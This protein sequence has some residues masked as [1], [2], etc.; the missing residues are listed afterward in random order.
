[1]ALKNR[2]VE[3]KPRERGGTL[4]SN[5]L[6]FQKDWALCKLLELQLTDQNYV[7]ILDFHDDILIIDSATEP[8][9]AQYYQLKTLSGGGSWTTK[10]LVS[11]KESEE[12]SHLGKLVFHRVSCPDEHV[13]LNFVS[14][15]GYKIKLE[16]RKNA[17]EALN[18]STICMSTLVESERTIINEKIHEEFSQDVPEFFDITY[19]RVT[20]LGIRGHDVY[21]KGKISE[22][23]DSY[24]RPDNRV[25]PSVAYK[26]LIAEI[27][28]RN[29]YEWELQSL[30]DIVCFKGIS[31]EC[32]SDLLEKLINN[33]RVYQNWTGI[34][35]DLLR[36]GAGVK[37]T[38]RIQG[39]WATY[40]LERMNM[41]NLVLQEIRSHVKNALELFKDNDF[42]N[43][44]DLMNRVLT[45]YKRKNVTDYRLFGYDEDY[46]RAIILMESCS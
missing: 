39:Y 5:R 8:Q 40:E 20:D 43:H 42:P 10:S 7:V 18:V 12:F 34:E 36:S 25:N 37:L 31:R 16:G 44:F 22:F 6:Q 2:L 28:K 1:M 13:E 24:A 46:I 19:L 29:D 23:L 30:E 41:T 17:K 15:A 35:Q 21:T 26:M 3:N 14:N 32:F 11:K 33:S 45:A 27:E 38:K 4:A 9:L